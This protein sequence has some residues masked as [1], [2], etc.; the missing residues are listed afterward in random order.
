MWTAGIRVPAEAR[1]FYLLPSRLAI[2][3]GGGLKR[4]RRETDH[5]HPVPRLKMVELYV[6]SA[7]RVHGTALN[8]LSTGTT[9]RL[10]KMS[11][12]ARHTL[13]WEPYQFGLQEICFHR[14]LKIGSSNFQMTT[15]DLCHYLI[16][17]R[18]RR[19]FGRSLAA[20]TVTAKSVRTRWLGF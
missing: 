2:Y 7:I 12:R 20:A 18:L 14:A 4:P 16:T 19:R 8:S 17:T 15:H 10:S 5:L 1:D 6:P 9:L 3:W 13:I 11:L